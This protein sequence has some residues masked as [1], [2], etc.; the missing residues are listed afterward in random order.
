MA[1]YVP[2]LTPKVLNTVSLE[3]LDGKTVYASK[4]KVLGLGN[5]WTNT[6]TMDLAANA[7]TTKD[8]R[9][10]ITAD[11]DG[12]YWFSRVTLFPQTFNNRKNGS[13]K[14]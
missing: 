12:K 4:K 3:S 2:R 5:T 13:V 6:F 14:I 9:F 10:R 8:A 1:H 11:E 7:P